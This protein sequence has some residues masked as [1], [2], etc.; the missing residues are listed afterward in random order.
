M[1]TLSTP[2][3]CPKATGGQVYGLTDRDAQAR[4]GFCRPSAAGWRYPDA[5]FS[6]ACLWECLPAGRDGRMQQ[7]PGKALYAMSR[8]LVAAVRREG[9][10]SLS[11][12]VEM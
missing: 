12:Y 9:W 7:K 3:G 5:P 1:L 10:G 11:Q 8:S 6:V 4:P 2:V